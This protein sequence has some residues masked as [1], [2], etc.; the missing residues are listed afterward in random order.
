MAVRLWMSPWAGA[1]DERGMGDDEMVVSP[2]EDGKSTQINEPVV[3]HVSSCPLCEKALGQLS[4]A[5]RKNHVNACLD[6]NSGPR[7]GPFVTPL[8]TSVLPPSSRCIRLRTI[9]ETYGKQCVRCAHDFAYGDGRLERGYNCW[10]LSRHAFRY[11]SIL[12]VDAYFLTQLSFSSFFSLN[13]Y[14]RTYS[15]GK[16][17][18][19]KA[20]AQAVNSE[21][22]CDS[23]EAAILRCQPDPELHALLTAGPLAAD[24]HILSLGMISLEKLQLYLS[25]SRRYSRRSSGFRPTGWTFS[26]LAGA[27][28]SPTIA[29]VIAQTQQKTFTAANL[30]PTRSTSSVLQLFPVPYSEHSSF[31]ELTCFA[32]SLKWG[33]MI[34]TVNVGSEG[35]RAKMARWVQKWEAEKEK[36][37]KDEVVPHR[38][39]DYCCTRVDALSPLS[40]FPVII[41]MMSAANYRVYG[42]NDDY[43]L[44]TDTNAFERASSVGAAAGDIARGGGIYP[45]LIVGVFHN[46]RIRTCIAIAAEANQDRMVVADKEAVEKLMNFFNAKKAPRW[47]THI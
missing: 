26:P 41:E 5:E 33:R 3:V 16:E 13:A 34:A 8:K 43:R 28:Q 21:I 18:I 40:L 42:V 39:A 38:R 44:G 29:S 9:L 24:V 10:S 4:E 20:V 32:L 27:V 23:R 47:Y 6:G 2:D 36:R 19:V 11:G 17:R 1:D 30:R 25:A 14:Y 22:Y 7:P 46:G 15:F 12:G 37:V 35:S 31:F 45:H